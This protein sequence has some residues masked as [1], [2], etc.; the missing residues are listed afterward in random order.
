MPGAGRSEIELEARVLA[1]DAGYEIEAE[2]FIT[3][4]TLGMTRNRLGIS[5]PYGKLIRAGA[6]R[7]RRSFHR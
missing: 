3:H 4:R 2:V 7:A 1:V 5:R 6:E